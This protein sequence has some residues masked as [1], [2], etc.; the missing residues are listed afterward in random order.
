MVPAATEERAAMKMNVAIEAALFLAS[1]SATSVAAA[2]QA[3]ALPSSECLVENLKADS[4]KAKTCLDQLRLDVEWLIAA[5]LKERVEA[6]AAPAPEVTPKEAPDRSATD[7][8]SAPAT[9]AAGGGAKGGWA[10]PFAGMT[11]TADRGE[12][13]LPAFTKKTYLLA[14]HKMVKAIKKW[15]GA[16]PP[17]KADKV[18]ATELEAK[19][20]A[21]ESDLHRLMDE[22]QLRQPMVA[23]FAPTYGPVELA[24]AKKQEATPGT[25][26]LPSASASPGPSPSP[27]PAAAAAEGTDDGA[28]ESFALV[29]ESREVKGVALTGRI[30]R[31]PMIV[32]A[33]S[34]GKAT[35]KFESVYSW[36]FGAKRSWEVRGRGQLGLFG[37][38]GQVF[39]QPTRT[40]TDQTGG[41]VL[42]LTTTGGSSWNYELGARASLFSVNEDPEEGRIHPLLD[43]EFGIRED[44][45]FKRLETLGNK[46]A[47]RWVFRLTLGEVS[48]LGQKA[49]VSFGVE[50][51]WARSG[52]VGASTRV[53]LKGSTDLF[54]ALSNASA[55]DP[56]PAANKP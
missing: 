31:A 13:F 18:R 47:R 1:V 16:G 36:A 42:T 32:V 8:K 11:M 21:L 15:A 29:F 3:Q 19:A 53:F 27:S 28:K 54:K 2:A 46:P 7:A 12:R 25:A 55:E 37:R 6:A 52:S 5:R 23:W 43:I 10:V 20:R 35:Q 51:E 41:K 33:E 48:V 39:G 40:L 4:A 34:D 9:A 26:A 24:V 45:R 22:E 50:H 38:G 30:T 44:R 17:A 49:G 56:K 14:V